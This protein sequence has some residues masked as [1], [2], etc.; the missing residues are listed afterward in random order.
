MR[1]KNALVGLT[2]MRASVTLQNTMYPVRVIHFQQ[3]SGALAELSW[4]RP[5]TA[6]FEVIPSQ[7]MVPFQTPTVIVWPSTVSFRSLNGT[8]VCC[9]RGL[10][11]CCAKDWL[12]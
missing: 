6:S 3:D 5:G 8:E 10:E 9:S 12:A 2:S 4:Q 1:G 11:R 7:Y